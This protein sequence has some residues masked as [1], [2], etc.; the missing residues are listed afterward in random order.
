MSTD[1]EH[2]LN[3]AD[4]TRKTSNIFAVSFVVSNEETWLALLPWVSKNPAIYQS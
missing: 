3:N 4:E 1:I 2:S